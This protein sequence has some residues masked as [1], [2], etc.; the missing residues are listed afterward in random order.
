[1]P[2][3]LDDRERALLAGEDGAGAALAMR[4]VAR[5]AEALDAPRLIPISRA[6]VDSCLYHGEATIDFVRRLADGGA[7]V[8]VPTTLNVGTLDLL[9]PE[10]WRG[11]ARTAERGRLLME[12]YRA[13]GCRPTYT[14]APY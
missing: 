4:L 2:L 10:L 11:D 9:H 13:L 8:A 14:C 7:R 12:L 6:H 5:A 1:M 3:A